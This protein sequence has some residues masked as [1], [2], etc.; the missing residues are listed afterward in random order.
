MDNNLFELILNYILPLLCAI[1]TIFIIPLIKERI[2]SE[3]LDQYMKW[4]TIG[5][6]AAEMIWKESGQGELKKEYV[7]EFLSDMFNKNK[8]VISTEQI[9]ALIEAAVQELNK[10]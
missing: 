9:D 8:V 6:K 3:R 5:V 2:G 7:T 1:I 10:K 4:A